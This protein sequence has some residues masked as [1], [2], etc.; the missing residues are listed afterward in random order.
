MDR[1]L[2]ECEEN[3]AVF[4]KICNALAWEQGRTE[5]EQTRNNK[6]SVHDQMYKTWAKVQKQQELVAGE[7]HVDMGQQATTTDNLIMG[8]YISTIWNIYW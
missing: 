6:N 1:E 5:G 8:S 4:D 3:F 7:E 2:H